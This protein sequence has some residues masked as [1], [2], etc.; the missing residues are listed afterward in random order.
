MADPCPICGDAVERV[1]EAPVIWCCGVA[2]S[3]AYHHAGRVC[4]RQE[5]WATRGEEDAARVA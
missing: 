2:T 5:R 4:V 3:R 1:S